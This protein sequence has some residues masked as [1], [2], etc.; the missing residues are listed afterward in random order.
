MKKKAR[1]KYERRIDQPVALTPLEYSGLQEAFDH[2]NAELFGGKLPDI[3]I[4]LQRRANTRGYFAADRFT[5]RTAKIGRHEL[6]L[7]PDTFVGRS[8]EDICSTLVHEQV[9]AWQQAFGN[10]SARTY[11]NREWAAKM[12]S[13]GLQPSS[14]GAVGG[15]ET[16]QSMTHY[17]IAEGPFA[18]AYAK[19]AKTEWKLNLQSAHRPGPSGGTNSKTKFSCSRCGQ[20]AWGKPDLNVTCTPCGV[21]MRA[22]G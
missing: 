11:H 14:T 5:G 8:D 20:N 12:K 19:L 17:I 4:T 1:R 15:K 21:R 18:K 16:G 2:F 3:F 10:P 7:N 22:A 9:H 13:L 6:A